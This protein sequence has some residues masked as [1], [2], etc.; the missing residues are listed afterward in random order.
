MNEYYYYKAAILSQL[1]QAVQ[2]VL[3]VEVHV[4][5]YRA[6]KYHIIV[7][8]INNPRGRAAS[9]SS[10]SMDAAAAYVIMSICL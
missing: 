10:S 2:S 8:R 4:S 3:Y 6:S 5:R 7:K 9:A 1:W